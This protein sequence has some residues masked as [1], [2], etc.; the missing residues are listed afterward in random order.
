M[1]KHFNS[2]D[3]LVHKN[4]KLYDPADGMKEVV[5]LENENIQIKDDGLSLTN[6][7]ILLDN[8]I[9]GPIKEVNYADLNSVEGLDQM[10]TAFEYVPE[11]IAGGYLN[12][13][14]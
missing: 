6:E 8:S 2:L 11:K 7:G 14:K 4:G 10:Q 5:P 9:K 12:F 13:K 1:M 3:G